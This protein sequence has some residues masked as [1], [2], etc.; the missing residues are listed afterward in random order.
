MALNGYWSLGMRTIINKHNFIV[1]E[2]GLNEW[3]IC[4]GTFFYQKILLILTLGMAHNDLADWQSVWADWS[5]ATLDGGKLAPCPAIYT[6][7]EV[8]LEPDRVLRHLFRG[9]YYL[10]DPGYWQIVIHLNDL[11]FFFIDLSWGP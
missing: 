7:G 9:P 3:I 10:G 4:I 1:G 2:E 6:Q 11:F 5:K 8:V